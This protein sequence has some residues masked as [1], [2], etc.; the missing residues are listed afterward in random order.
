MFYKGAVGYLDV[1]TPPEG[2]FEVKVSAKKWSWLMSYGRGTMHP[3][4]HILVDEPTKL[5]MTSDDVIHS[6]YVP[7][8]RAK[9]DIVP[10]RYNYMWFQPTVASKKVSDEELAK[11]KEANKGQPWDYHRWQFTEDGYKFYDLYCTEY[12]G[13]DHSIM[14]TVVV[15]HETQE[16]LD[17][18]IK[19]YSQRGEIPMEEWGRRLY[20]QRGCKGCHSIDGSRGT[21]PSYKDTFGTEQQMANG[22]MVLVD[23]NYIRESILNPK[24]KVRATYNPIMP[25]Y[26]GQLSDDDI[27]SLIAFMKTLQRMIQKQHHL[28]D[29]RVKTKRKQKRKKPTTNNLLGLLLELFENQYGYRIDSSGFDH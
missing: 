21:G 14:Q 7:A 5:V 18:W 6:L 1:R 3:E 22:D 16:D 29:L 20:E 15:V 26:K 8:F 4:L 11:A 24:A 19:K 9:K 27:D 28:T 12:C 2:G 23:E 25:S 10:G 13:K 17:A